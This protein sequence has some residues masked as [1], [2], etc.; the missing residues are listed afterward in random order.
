MVGDE[1]MSEKRFNFDEEVEFE[2]FDTLTKNHYDGRI[3]CQEKICDLLNEQQAKISKQLSQ[4]IEL[5]DKYRILNF[6]YG[7]I[8]A[9]NKKQYKKIG[10]QQTTITNLK[11]D[12]ERQKYIIEQKDSKIM[13]LFFKIQELKEE[14]SRLKSKIGF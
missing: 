8:E 2:I 1:Y 5:Q 11:G 13:Q 9:R 6:N 3:G 4:I 7:R 10:K 14:N 12:I